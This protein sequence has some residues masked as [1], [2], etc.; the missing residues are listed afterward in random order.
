[1]LGGGGTLAFKDKL[2]PNLP[3]SVTKSFAPI[4]H[5]VDTPLLWLCQ[6]L[7]CKVSQGLDCNGQQKAEWVVLWNLVQ[8][9]N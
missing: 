4:V 6:L 1:M 7:P 2:V 3:Y 5:V 8:Q 9:V